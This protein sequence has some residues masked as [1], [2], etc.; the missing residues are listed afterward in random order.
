[1]GVF[2]QVFN[3]DLQV[4]QQEF[5]FSSVLSLQKEALVIPTISEAKCKKVSVLQMK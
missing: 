1:M 2:L 4:R 5:N 3:V